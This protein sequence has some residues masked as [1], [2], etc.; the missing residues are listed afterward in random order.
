MKIKTPLLILSI[1]LL[2]S[3]KALS[4]TNVTLQLNWKYQ[5][6]FAGYIA[7]KEKGFYKKEGLNVK[8]IP[9]NGGSV[10]KTVLDGKAD[11]G[12]T[13]SDI[14]TAII[15]H[16]P[17]IFLA[18]FFK[19]SPLVLAV[20]PSIRTPL[21]LKHKKIMADENEF[22]FT[23]LGLLL[24]KFKIKPKD[25]VLTKETYSI[26]PFIEGKVDGMAIYITNEPYYLNRKHVRYNII[27][28]AN[29]GI[30]AYSGNLFTSRKYFNKNPDVVRKF[31]LATIK[32]WRYALEHKK[33]I[34]K[35]IN[36]KYSKEKSIPA[37][38]FEAKAI[39]K[40]IMP[41]VFPL[42]FIDKN[43]VIQTLDEFEDIL[44]KNPEPINLN[45]Y[46]YSRRNATQ[47]FTKNELKF[48]KNH[49][50][51]KICTNP[52]WKPIEYL[53]NGKPEG[54]SIDVLKEISSITGLKF[55][56]IPTKTWT[57]SQEFLKDKKCDLLPSA[58]KTY[59][60]EK[61]AIFTKPYLRYE[62][63]I[64]AKSDKHFVNGINSIIGKSIARKKGSGLITK[65]K[66]L[67]PSIKIIETNSYKQSFEYVEDGKAY[68]TIATLPV[69]NYI[70]KKY[71]YNDIVII[72]DTGLNYKISMAVR[73]DFPTL[74]SILNKSLRKVTSTDLD[75]MY[76]KQINLAKSSMYNRL[77][78]KIILIFI[79]VTTILSVVII[80]IARV[81][82]KLKSTKKRLEESVRNFE[83][84]TNYTIQAIIIYKNETC[85]EA[86]RVACELLGYKREELIGT[87]IFRLL[88][89]KSKAEVRKKL[90]EEH[91]EPYEIEFV[92]K[93][94]KI[95][96]VLSKGDYITLNGERVRVGSAVDITELKKL[97]KKLRELNETLEKKVKE[98]LEEI[99]RKDI[100]MLQQS[101]L[102]SMGEMLSMIA[103]QWRQ[104]LNTIAANINTLLLKIEMG[105]YNPEFL[106]QKL[107]NIM[108]YVKHL[109]ETIEDFRDFFKQDKT[110][111]STSIDEVIENTLKIAKDSLDR[112][113]IE[114][115]LK[116]NAKTRV[117]IYANE[118]KHVVLNLINNARDALL[119]RNVESPYIKIE[120][121][122][123]ENKAFIKVSDNAGGIEENIMQQIFEP[124]FTTKSSKEG[125]GIG[126]Y[127]SKII[128]ENHM[129]GS[130]YAKNTDSGAEFIV[131]IPKI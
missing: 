95:V 106:K 8:I 119:E 22:N 38:M 68:C 109:S 29:Y 117:N 112:A 83:I 10:I 19:K 14:F 108:D 72:G 32:G 75:V 53:K 25:L 42:G 46:I 34:V 27:D 6:E 33:E 114:L 54:I 104:P 113:N 11:F 94:G 76:L 51:I 89:D 99:R 62:L 74:V 23:S 92:R 26:T 56:R 71:R 125:T 129:K 17:I 30:F 97:Q 4:L 121:Y 18:N 105:N 57:Q 81:N 88:T 123:T 80:I 60:R 48:I 100:V 37:L 120:T 28:P 20:K 122:E 59:K 73:K 43:V 101:K 85:I 64:F 24:H 111:I 116:L 110:K 131:E 3:S 12:V 44:S 58:V 2:L 49:K 128:I 126:L 69:A 90:K 50:T 70:I 67:Y 103:H 36:K 9:Y 21:E 7:A 63:F 115:N 15:Y 13:D 61:Y 84:L 87:S 65:L 55:V 118:L 102:A 124:Y 79:I 39:Q 45:K 127:M 96:Y 35:L 66:R 40:I 91:T 82:K 98:A 16:K 47:I 31:L 5:F 93:D 77:I 86:N 52:D 78:L 1:I 107:L 41:D 130:I